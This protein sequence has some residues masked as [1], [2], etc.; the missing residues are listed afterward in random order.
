MKIGGLALYEK[1]K[2]E[3]AKQAEK[4]PPNPAMKGGESVA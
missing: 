3:Q 2:A 1:V 4:Q